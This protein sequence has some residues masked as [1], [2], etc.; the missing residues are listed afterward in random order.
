MQRFRGDDSLRAIEFVLY[1]E[2]EI[3]LAVFEARNNSVC[4][5]GGSP[6]GHAYIA[7]PTAIQAVRNAEELPSVTLSDGK[8][9]SL[10]EKWLSVIDKLREWASLD[11]IA[12]GILHDR[13]HEEPWQYSTNRLNI[14]HTTYTNYLDRIR[15]QAKIIAAKFDLI[16]I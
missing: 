9:L 15:T 13:Y 5:T 16:E 11:T 1:N 3:R 7:D 4:H 6:S 2:R 14:S 12:H 10:P 8:T